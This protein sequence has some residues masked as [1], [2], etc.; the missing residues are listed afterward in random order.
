M[1]HIII[2]LFLMVHIIMLFCNGSGKNDQR[3]PSWFTQSKRWEGRKLGGSWFGERVG[4]ERGC[5]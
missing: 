1:V 5:L 4:G 2:A 3:S